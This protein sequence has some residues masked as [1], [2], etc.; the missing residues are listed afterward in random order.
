MCLSTPL[1]AL[2]FSSISCQFKS[3]YIIKSLFQ[4][5]RYILHLFLFSPPET[6][7]G[8]SRSIP[9][10]G[11]NALSPLQKAAVTNIIHPSMH[12]CYLF[13][14]RGGF[15]DERTKIWNYQGNDKILSFFF[16][17]TCSIFFAFIALERVKVNR[18]NFGWICEPIPWK[19]YL[20]QIRCYK[21]V[22]FQIYRVKGAR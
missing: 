6:P 12:T 3:Q 20:R 16:L 17:F 5:Y 2:S 22:Q 13:R 15:Q 14:D 9:S 8:V 11:N 7:F 21:Y 19:F 10:H 1:I 18:Q 4:N